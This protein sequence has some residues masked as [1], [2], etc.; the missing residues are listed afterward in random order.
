M[1]R[2]RPRRSL[3]A[4]GACLVLTGACAPSNEEACKA[5]AER[6]ERCG[7]KDDDRWGDKQL[8]LCKGTLDTIAEK[9]KSLGREHAKSLKKCS[10]LGDCES[11]RTCLMVLLVDE[12][13][14]ARAIGCAKG[15]ADDCG[16]LDASGARKGADH[17]IIVDRGA[18]EGSAA[19]RARQDL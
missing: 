1:G 19:P 7:A 8:A 15:R 2:Q 12:Q 3:A 16:R 13:R 6:F 10:D 9:D 11:A 17:D 4:L 14:Q 18:S 5:A